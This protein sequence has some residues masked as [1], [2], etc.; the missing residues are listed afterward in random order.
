M[1][2]IGRAGARGCMVHT[3]GEAPAGDGIRGVRIMERRL[4]NALD[5]GQR[6]PRSA[7]RWL[8]GAGLLP[9]PADGFVVGIDAKD[10]HMLISVVIPTYNRPAL[11][12]EALCSVAEQTYRSFE[13][14]VVDNGSEPP[15]SRGALEEVLG[16]RVVLRRY[17]RPQGVPKS[18]NAGVRS[19]RG[20]IIL[21]LDDDDLLMPDALESIY[22]AFSSHPNIDCLFLGVRPF[23][24]YAQGPAEA[25][26][27][28]VAKLLEQAKPEERDGLYFFSDTLFHALLHTVP[29]DFQRPAARHGVWNII[30]GFDENSLYSESAWAIR[31]A[32]IAT[33]ALTSKPLTQW[34]IHD[35]N[36]GWPADMKVDDI[37]RRQTDN[38]ITSGYALMKM[39]DEQQRQ[40]HLRAREIRKYQS[41]TLFS[42][43]YRLCGKAWREGMYALL[44]SFRVAPRPAHLKL[45]VKYF[46]P[47]RWI[48]KRLHAGGGRGLDGT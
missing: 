29:I 18:K 28:A 44:C 36:F 37:R 21:L 19:A 11:L 15:I 41:N 38:A 39:F 34:R 9:V 4:L 14:V 42:K 2:G 8:E 7:A 1:R 24:P 35:S 32:S 27:R 6:L 48:R 33:V 31:V 45:A 17:D 47:M 22:Q 40:S 43:A 30:G 20:E 10:M 46:L 13:V 5:N 3:F 16:S 25:R 12:K 23:G 26:E